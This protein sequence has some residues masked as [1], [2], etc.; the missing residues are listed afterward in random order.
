MRTDCVRCETHVVSYKLPLPLRFS[1]LRGRLFPSFCWEAR[2]G[3]F[4]LLLVPGAIS[5]QCYGRQSNRPRSTSIQ[6][7][8]S[9][10]LFI[11]NV[12]IAF[13]LYTQRHNFWLLFSSKQKKDR[14]RTVCSARPAFGVVYPASHAQLRLPPTF[15]SIWYRPHSLFSSRQFFWCLLFGFDF[16][17][18]VD[19]C[20]M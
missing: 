4:A 19:T 20:K 6:L 11:F 17:F 14:C 7:V 2:T 8:L 12:L 3:V 15:A 1:P 16:F 10:I 13:C 9:L 18:V 5:F